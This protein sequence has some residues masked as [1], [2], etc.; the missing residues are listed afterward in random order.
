MSAAPDLSP[1]PADQ[2]IGLA[3][4]VAG[5]PMTPAILYADG[6]VR[7]MLARLSRNDRRRDRRSRNDRLRKRKQL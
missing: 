5:Q 4:V 1:E 7:A 3:L 2:Q 6:G